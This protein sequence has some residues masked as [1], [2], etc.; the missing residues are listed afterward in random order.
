MIE[1]GSTSI[2]AMVPFPDEN[3]L[4]DDIP[5]KLILFVA[6]SALFATVSK[7]HD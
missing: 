4:N 7:L 5:A 1:P 6:A 2:F 3:W